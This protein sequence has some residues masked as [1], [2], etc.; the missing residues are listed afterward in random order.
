MTLPASSGSP[1]TPHPAQLTMDSDLLR[2]LNKRFMRGKGLDVG[3]FDRPFFTEAEEKEF[4]VEVDTIDRWNPEEL[5]SLFLELPDFA[6]REAT[7]YGDVSADGLSMFESE[8][9]DFVICSHV[10][11]HVANPF[12][13]VEELAR[14]LKPNGVLYL[15]I[16]EG[17]FGFDVGRKLTTYEDLLLLRETGVRHISDEQVIDF[18]KSP[19]IAQNPRIAR[20][21]ASG[22]PFPPRA[23]ESRRQR[24]FHVH[25]WDTRE[26]PLQITR[27]A[28]HAG[29]DLE[30]LDLSLYANNGYEGVVIFRKLAGRASGNLLAQVSELVEARKQYPARPDTA[31]RK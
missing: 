22:K 12:W 18:L 9:Y 14:V 20:Q 11:E 23:L 5:K 17:R 29:L 4:E 21:L 15:A 6:P 27:F 24:S 2:R 8:S 25:V 3:P 19:R 10:L 31:H 16:P 1:K 26:F 28:L 30:L 13:L 7:F